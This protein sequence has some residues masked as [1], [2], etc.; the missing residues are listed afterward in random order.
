MYSVQEKE[1]PDKRLA[2]LKKHTFAPR[3][4]NFLLGGHHTNS[5][6]KQVAEIPFLGHVPLDQVTNPQEYLI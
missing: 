5:G 2:L 3:M 1:A 4:E 6:I